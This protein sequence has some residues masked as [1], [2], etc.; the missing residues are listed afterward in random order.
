MK[1]ISI[2]FNIERNDIDGLIIRNENLDYNLIIYDNVPGGA[3]HIKRLNDDKTLT[4]ALRAAYQKVNPNC[5]EENISCYNCLRNYY[6][7][8][9]HKILL[10]KSAK[11]G[12]KYILNEKRE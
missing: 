8:K 3:G 11:E 2:A 12:I 4:E 9:Y 5:C 1:G 7:Q 10:R 6:N